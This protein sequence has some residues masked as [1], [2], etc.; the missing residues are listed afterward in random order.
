[1]NKPVVSAQHQREH[2]EPHEKRQPIPLLVLAMVGML[3][4]FGI[5][6]IAMSQLDTPSEWGD[7]RSHA[8]L[9]GPSNNA[10]AAG[11]ADGAAIYASRCAA[12]HQT[13][14]AGLAGVFP[15]LAGSEWVTGKEKTLTA[16]VLHGVT[17]QLT[18]KGA[19]YNGSM[20]AFK[21]Q[22][23]DTEIA[24]VLSYI[25]SQWKNDAGAIAAQMVTETRTQTQDR[26]DPLKGDADLAAMN[27]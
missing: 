26:K 16:I 17:G 20:P 6:Y 3:L 27:L 1:M 21:D 12:C 9:A 23:N 4:V 5:G 18:V 7:G 11:V 22:L 25:R 24:A 13:N 10:L 15:P 14:G 19:A 8:E 2:E